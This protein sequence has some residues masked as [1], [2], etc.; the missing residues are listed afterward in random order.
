M[1][2][3][4]SSKKDRDGVR[5]GTF[6][7]RHAYIPNVLLRMCI[8]S[9]EC[10]QMSTEHYKLKPSET[11]NRTVFIILYYFVLQMGNCMTSSGRRSITWMGEERE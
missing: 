11:A 7:F 8:Y 1:P 4:N 5:E 6:T 2:R 10:S 9:V 3:E